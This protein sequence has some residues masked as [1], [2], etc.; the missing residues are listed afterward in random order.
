MVATLV[1]PR[2]DAQTQPPPAGTLARRAVPAGEESTLL[3]NLRAA[4][5][6]ADV[7]P[8]TALDGAAAA[9]TPL[10]DALDPSFASQVQLP[11]L[12]V[13]ITPRIA[14]ALALA[15]IDDRSRRAVAS[16]LR[17]ADRYRGR[18]ESWLVA[19]GVPTDLVWVVAAESGFNPN[20]VS[21]VGATG[22]WQLMS[23]AARTYGLRIDGW[24]DERRDPERSTHAAARML[25]DL[26]Q[27]FGSWELALAAYNMGYNALLR[28]I[29]K[30]NSN[31]FET[32]ASLEAG[33][34]WETTHYVPRI[35]SSAIVARNAALFSLGAGPSDAPI[36]WE[37]CPLAESVPLEVIA[38]ALGT[39]I[40]V[41]HQ[42]NPSLLRTRT[43]PAD[44]MHPF[45]L[46]VPQGGRARV[47][48][49][50]ARASLTPTRPYRIRLGET[51]DDV[52]ARYGW[53]P[54]QLA[55]LSG[56]GDPRAMASGQ[57][58]L[59]PDREA[60]RTSNPQRPVIA[61]QAPAEVPAGRRRVFYRVNAGDEIGAIARATGTRADEVVRW[62]AVDPGARLHSGMWLQMYIVGQ[63]VDARVWE[64]T[65]VDRIER[66]SEEFHDRAVALE[67]RVRLRVTL[68]DGDTMESIARRYGLSAG[69]LARINQRSRHASLVAGESIVVYADPSTIAPPTA[70]SVVPSSPANDDVR[71]EERPHE[72]AA[73]T[74]ARCESVV[75][76]P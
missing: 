76:T 45:V 51:A 2:L 49:A 30:N 12:T 46:H 44:A 35:L 18:I 31:D 68:R 55:G 25:R 60:L 71:D 28:A 65:E 72:S 21:R 43:P 8:G 1:S 61:V 14:R 32:L 41:V 73:P 53:T 9:G 58:I 4:E 50:V 11:G 24:V 67:G 52:A 54:S 33:L 7:R 48:A 40:A 22:L 42:L 6:D 5:R 59:V 17:R 20:D 23:D 10:P 19:E 27:R 13:R 15:R 47:D 34:P 69:L 39:D 70:V 66:G 36:V 63:P 75:A 62:N 16:W 37:D 74:P 26:H 3:A 57:D 38:R 64:E 29:R 56:I